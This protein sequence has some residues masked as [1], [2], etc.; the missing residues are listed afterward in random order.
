MALTNSCLHGYWN[1]SSTLEA[2]GADDTR[3]AFPIRHT[4][5]AAACRREGAPNPG[6]CTT[7]TPQRRCIHLPSRGSQPSPRPLSQISPC[8]RRLYPCHGQL[9]RAA[10]LVV[11]AAGHPC[12]GDTRRINSRD[13][14]HEMPLCHITV[15]SLSTVPR[16]TRSTRNT[17]S[18]SLLRHRSHC[19]HQC[20]CRST[21]C[22]CGLSRAHQNSAPSSGCL[23]F[24]F[25]DLDMSALIDISTSWILLSY[26]QLLMTS[27]PVT[28]PV[29]LS[30]HGRLIF[31]VNRHVGGTLG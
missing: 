19:L 10:P 22:A 27:N 2:R 1:S 11:Q 26:R 29:V 5:K 31:V 20:G 23:S 4:W 14:A 21:L 8:T 13:S 16:V 7:K 15:R 18:R 6:R 12:P 3:K 25:D 24:R 9:Q 30:T 17:L 28:S